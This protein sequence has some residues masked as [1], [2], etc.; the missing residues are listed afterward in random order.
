MTVRVATAADL[1]AIRELDA[2]VFGSDAWGAGAWR[3][4]WEQIP[5]TRHIVVAVEAERVVGFAVLAVAADVADLH[6]VAV[7]PAARRRGLGTRLV[8]A[9]VAEAVR[10]GCDRML[11]EVEAGNAAAVALY[12]RFGF[13]EIARRPAYYGPGRDALI[14]ER[15]LP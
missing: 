11:L 15:A 5:A 12:G 4:E 7:A 10:R 8:E 14:L 6:R 2:Q 1:D 9:V 3:G 13:A